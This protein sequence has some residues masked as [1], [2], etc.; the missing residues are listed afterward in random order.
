[1]LAELPA[2]EYPNLAATIVELSR[3]GYAFSQ[4]FEVGLDLVL[5]GIERLLDR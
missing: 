4:G 3:S 5:E 1:M 2:D